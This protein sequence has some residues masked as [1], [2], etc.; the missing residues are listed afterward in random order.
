[1]L[2]DQTRRLVRLSDD[3]AA[4]T[5]A[6]ESSVSMTCCF[7]DVERLARRCAAAAQE[8]YAAKKVALRVRVAD[9]LPQLWVD[10][11]R[12]SQVVGNLLDNAL[13]HTPSDGW[14]EVTGLGLEAG[15]EVVT[16]Q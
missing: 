15:I 3:V 14:V 4:L 12:L 1:M 5:Q 10:E 16:P 7:I 6:E 2:R 11:Q 8:R 9:G 13:R